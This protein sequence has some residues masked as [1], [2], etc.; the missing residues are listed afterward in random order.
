M[1]VQRNVDSHDMSHVVDMRPH[2]LDN[3]ALRQ[4]QHLFEQ[5]LRMWVVQG[6]FG[7]GL[8]YDYIDSSRGV[9]S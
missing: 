6:I 3:C 8:G 2:A 5:T 7:V 1:V 4:F 9:V